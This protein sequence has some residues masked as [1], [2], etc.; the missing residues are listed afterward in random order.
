MGRTTNTA[1]WLDG[2]SEDMDLRKRREDS[3]TDQIVRRA[4][5]L[6][7]RDCELVLLMFRD[8]RSARSIALLNDDCP[9]QIRR[10]IKRLVHRLQD[11]RVA[12]VVAH[13]ESWSKSRKSI[14]RALFIQGRSIRET[15]DELGLSFY[16]VRK[17]REAI[18]AMCV[19]AM[20]TPSPSKLRAWR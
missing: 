20:D 3:L 16:S 2:I 8:G 19:A 15:T 18:D 9:R 4:H 1:D 7:P 10:R 5:W 11:P 13:H 14:A 17:H 12:Y 6:E